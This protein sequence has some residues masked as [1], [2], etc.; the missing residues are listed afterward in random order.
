MTDTEIDLEQIFRDEED[1]PN[2]YD[3]LCGK[4]YRH[5]PGNKLF[6]QLVE[7]NCKRYQAT[8][9]REEK[10]AI[11]ARVIAEVI[12]LGGKFLTLNSDNKNKNNN[13]NNSSNCTNGWVLADDKTVKEKVSHALRSAKDPNRQVI[14][15]KRKPIEKP[16]FTAKE[17]MLL[18]SLERRRSAIFD[19]LVAE[20]EKTAGSGDREGECIAA[21]LKDT[22]DCYDHEGECIV[23]ELK[24]VAGCHDHEGQCIESR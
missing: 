3:V 19:R 17:N 13:N 20:L 8:P 6:R 24:D 18:A 7:Q 1:S 9:R 4:E 21:E 16:E 5:H 11:T 10:A 12:Q 14:R 15:K 2:P 22:A 23:A